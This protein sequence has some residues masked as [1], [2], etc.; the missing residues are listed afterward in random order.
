MLKTGL[1][2]QGQ[3]LTKE[4]EGGNLFTTVMDAGEFGT[5]EGPGGSAVT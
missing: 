3:V 1:M 2:R 5:D 4:S